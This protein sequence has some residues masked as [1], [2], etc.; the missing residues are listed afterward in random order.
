MHRGKGI[1]LRVSTG[2]AIE[3]MTGVFYSVKLPKHPPYQLGYTRIQDMKFYQM[4]SNMWSEEFY[5]KFPEH[6]RGESRDICGD[7]GLVPIFS[8][9]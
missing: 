2:F 5:H 3:V 1:L 9:R 4:W 7:S 6:S 8:E